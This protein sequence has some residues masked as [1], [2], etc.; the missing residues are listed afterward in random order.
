MCRLWVKHLGGPHLI[1]GWHWKQRQRLPKEEIWLQDCF[2]KPC[3]NSQASSLP[4]R[5]QICKTPQL[6]ELIPRNF[7]LCVSGLLVPCLW[8]M[9]MNAPL[10]TEFFISTEC[11]WSVLDLIINTAKIRAMLVAEAVKS[12]LAMQETWVWALGPEDALEKGMAM[13]SSIPAQRITWTEGGY[14]P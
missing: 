1:S 12:L 2:K 14:N 4:Y 5:F 7:S 8:I 10:H 9:L 13:H 6:H 11:V 3:L